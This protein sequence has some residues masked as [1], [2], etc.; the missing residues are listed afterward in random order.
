LIFEAKLRGEG[1]LPLRATEVA[2][3]QVNVGKLCNQACRHCH[4]DA[5]P[6]RTEVMTAET[7]EL[8]ADVIRRHDFEC[9]DI[10]GG[11]PEL[12]P[13]FRLLVDTAHE[14]G[15]R[16]VDR[17]NLTVF[18]ADGMDWVP[19]YLAAR[20]VEVV[21]SLPYYLEE[22]VDRQ[23]GGGVFDASVKALRRLNEL[24]YGAPDSGLV[25][26][27]IY[28]PV[29]AYL[30]PPQAGIEADYRRELEGRYDIRFNG[31]L[32]ITNM[33]ISRFAEWLRRSG[34]YD[35]YMQK[36]SGAFNPATLPALMC[37]HL[38]SVGWDGRLHDCDFNQMLDL[39]IGDG[40]AHIRDFDARALARR[41]IVVGDHCLGCTAGA[42]SSCGGSIA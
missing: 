9:V 19:E 32:T 26:N 17:C 13:G 42:G 36:L 30:P 41:R 6:N 3:L 7:A 35:R 18:F 23:R 34:N 25:L 1:Q 8:V 15:M 27:L 4:V 22:Q 29:G 2:T 11:A 31:L 16:V 14:R 24:G 40:P 5:G 28:N 39:E 21:A 33:P 10:T 20:E 12:C 38:V 37:R